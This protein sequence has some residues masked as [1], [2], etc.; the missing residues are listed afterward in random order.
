MPSRT[1][2]KVLIG[3]QKLPDLGENFYQPTVIRDMTASMQFAQDETFGPVAGLFKFETEADVVE[4]A[5]AADVGLGGLFLQQGYPTRVSGCRGAW[6]LV[7]W[8]GEHGYHLRCGGAVWRRQ[9]VWLWARREL[10]RH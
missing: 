1:G 4:L 9:G 5:N 6:K 3:G 7:W 2:G 8:C 10:A